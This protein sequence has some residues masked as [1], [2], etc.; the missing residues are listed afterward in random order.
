MV[1]FFRKSLPANPVIL[2]NGKKFMFRKYP[3]GYGYLKTEDPLLVSN[4]TLAAEKRLFGISVISE[5][6]YEAAL[7][8]NLSLTPPEASSRTEPEP[9]LVNLFPE[10]GRPGRRA[11]APPVPNEGRL[12]SRRG[13]PQEAK[14]ELPI[15]PGMPI[16]AIRGKWKPI[17]GRI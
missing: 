14:R 17:A 11:V 10:T 8:K 16:P 12:A 4:F 9:R 5:Q 1:K 2:T 7:K 3:D 6:D 15:T 13:Q